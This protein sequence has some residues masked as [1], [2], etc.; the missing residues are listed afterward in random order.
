MTAPIDRRIRLAILA[1]HPIQYQAPLYRRLARSTVVD[2]EVLFCSDHGMTPTYDVGFARKVVYD[3]PLTTGY[4]HRFFR[5]IAPRPAVNRPL[6][7]V[8]PGLVRALSSSDFDAVMVHGYAIASHWLAFSAA[9][10]RHLPYLLRGETQIKTERAVK[11]A[12]RA[13]KRVILGPLLRGASCCLA[14]G[15]GN[16]AFY[17]SYGVPP[18]RVRFAPY[19]VDNDRFARAGNE[20]RTRRAELLRSLGLDPGRPTIVYAAKLLS[21]KRPFDLLAAVSRMR[22]R[23][24]LLIIGDGPL[25]PA[26]EQRVSGMTCARLLGFV[27]Q[28]EIGRWYGLAD[29]FVLPSQREPW[30]LAVN[31]AMAAGAVPVVS[32]AVGCASDLVTPRSG[33]T[34]PVGDIRALAAVLD[35]LVEDSDL[36]GRLRSEASRI[37]DIFSIEATARGIEDG[38]IM[39]TSCRPLRS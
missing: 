22:T 15:S 31:E 2:A 6:G 35:E 32:D 29:V 4:R 36:R 8:N 25:Q 33:R 1:S 19:S 12:K 11:P 7:L 18:E 16:R 3:V 13:L 9:Q 21:L 37:L 14:I 20:G 30:G 17:E 10:A 24:N 28:Q 34:Y 38:A 26:V 23:V 27:N 39:A 5:N